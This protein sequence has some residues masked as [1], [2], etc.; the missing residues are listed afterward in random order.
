MVVV[1]LSGKAETGKSETAK[2]IKEWAYYKIPSTRDVEFLKLAYGDYVKHTAERLLDWNG[3]KDEQG[4]ALLQWWGTEYVRERF[5]DFWADSLVRLAEVVA[6]NTELLIV[7]DLRYLNEISC[8]DKF[9][10]AAVLKVRIERPGHENSLTPKQRQHPSEVSLDDY[11]HFDILLS[12]TNREELEDEVS[13]KLLP[14]IREELWTYYLSGRL[15]RK[16]SL[17]QVIIKDAIN[18][19]REGHMT[20]G[21]MRTALLNTYI[22]E[23]WKNKVKKM[24]ARQVM[25]IYYRLYLP[26]PKTT[27][28]HYWTCDLCGSNLD[29]GERC[30]CEDDL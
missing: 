10:K 6:D 15:W 14:R 19:M 11:E 29:I 12:A 25:A 30:D 1:L 4:R 22:G 21:E 20:I 24:H 13:R 3:E 9:E 2:I 7:D 5:P 28:E 27:A 26:P 23:Q 16:S 18:S 8:W 17:S